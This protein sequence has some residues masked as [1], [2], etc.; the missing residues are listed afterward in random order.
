M[1]PAAWPAEWS[2]VDDIVRRAGPLLGDTAPV[3]GAAL[4]RA[5]ALGPGGV[6][7]EV[8]ASGLRGRGGAGFRTAQKWSLCR[9]AAGDDLV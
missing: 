6:I 8:R 2:Q 7:D 3:P 1:P 4:A 9:E 5:L